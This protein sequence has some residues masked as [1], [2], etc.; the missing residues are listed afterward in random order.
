MWL[1][2][3][4]G[5]ADRLLHCFRL[6]TSDPRLQTPREGLT[7]SDHNLS[8]FTMLVLH[9]TSSCDICYDTYGQENPASTIPCG[10]I[11]C[12]R[13]VRVRAGGR[14]RRYTRRFRSSVFVLIP[15]SIDVFPYA[16][17]ACA[18]CAERSSRAPISRNS[19]RPT[20][21]TVEPKRSSAVRFRPH[22]V[23]RA[24]CLNDGI[25]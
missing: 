25:L 15:S 19:G 18:R 3:H 24:V 2:E 12:Y 13:C 8:S 6:P 20:L 14:P 22:R 10:H 16:G 21:G 1:E 5:R 23:R 11:F 7:R 9:P 4:F 17:R